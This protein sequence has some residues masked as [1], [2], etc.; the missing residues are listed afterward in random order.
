MRPSWK[1]LPGSKN[2]NYDRKKFHNIGPLKWKLQMARRE[3]TGIIKEQFLE[4]KSFQALN[5]STLQL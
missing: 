4:K 5:W 3:M 2:I 1:S